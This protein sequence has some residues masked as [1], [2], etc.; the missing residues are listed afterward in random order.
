MS[1]HE[2]KVVC[3]E[4]IHETRELAM[5]LTSRH[6][7]RL[8]S[9][10]SQAFERRKSVHEMDKMLSGLSGKNDES[11]HKAPIMCHCATCCCN[12]PILGTILKCIC[13]KICVNKSYVGWFRDC[14][15]PRFWIRYFFM[16]VMELSLT[17]Y[18]TIT[19]ESH[20]DS[21][22]SHSEDRKS[23]ALVLY[24]ASLALGTFSMVFIRSLFRSAIRSE[25]GR[26]HI[27]ELIRVV[28]CGTC[29]DK[30]TLETKKVPIEETKDIESSVREQTTTMTINS[31]TPET[32]HDALRKLKDNL[33]M[34]EIEKQRQYDQDETFRKKIN[35]IH[36][37][38][39][40]FLYW[41]ARTSDEALLFIKAKSMK[42]KNLKDKE[43]YEEKIR[44]NETQLAY[45]HLQHG[46]AGR[47]AVY[48]ILQFV[49][50]IMVKVA[51]L[52]VLYD[53]EKTN[54]SVVAQLYAT[55]ISL[56]FLMAQTFNTL[57]DFVTNRCIL[58]VFN[59]ILEAC[60]LIATGVGCFSILTI[61]LTKHG[62]LTSDDI[63]F[64]TL[65]FAICCSTLLISLPMILLERVYFNC[66]RTRGHIWS[67]SPDVLDE[68]KEKLSLH[69]DVWNTAI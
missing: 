54:R 27:N 65:Y 41:L 34:W 3:T 1:L 20:Y 67:I 60:T 8:H 14:T 36:F 12:I 50:D 28:T 16:K 59:R 6:L 43:I 52:L 66:T 56:V 45:K 63:S 22:T 29:H 40:H 19:F 18:N 7:H 47:F 9:L 53:G 49:G 38:R 48:A 23:A 10:G 33:K 13:Y 17:L 25:F 31:I 57:N 62:T 46:V 69:Y 39:S 26:D 35:A 44:F 37:N 42:W 30:I 11:D 58:V 55:Q 51:S 68:R 2:R 61:L 32:P 15:D 21:N 24:I 64:Y 4:M 5:N